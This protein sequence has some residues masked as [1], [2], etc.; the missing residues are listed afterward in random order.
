MGCL[1]DVSVVHARSIFFQ[2]TRSPF[3]DKR[4][5]LLSACTPI[6]R[7]PSPSRPYAPRQSISAHTKFS[8]EI[9]TYFC[10]VAARVSDS[11]SSLASQKRQKSA[12]GSS[13]TP[14]SSLFYPR[15]ARPEYRL[16]LSDTGRDDYAHT[17]WLACMPAP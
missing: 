8:L 15:H 7:A 13:S 2:C 14:A 4:A 6:S 1:Q 11:P 5:S 3:R 9:Q 10:R 17:S 16:P 12:S